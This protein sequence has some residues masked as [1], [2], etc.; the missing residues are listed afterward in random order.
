[1]RAVFLFASVRL[2]TPRSSAMGRKRL[3]AIVRYRPKADMPTRLHRTIGPQNCGPI[4]T[5]S[6]ALV[7]ST[8]G[9]PVSVATRYQPRLRASILEARTPTH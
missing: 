3:S 8:R 9:G 1:M 4:L 2:T 6:D 5:K 7:S